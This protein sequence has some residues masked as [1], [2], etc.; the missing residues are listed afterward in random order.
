VE[1]HQAHA[2]GVLTGG[3]DAPGLNA[4]IRGVVR[5]ASQLGWSVYGFERGFEGLLPPVS[6]RRLTPD[7]TRGILHRGGTILGAV[8]RGRFVCKVGEGES[9]GIDP[10]ILE[11]S[12][13]TCR[14]LGLRGLIC[15]GGDGSLTIAQQLC[16]YGLPVV[17][18]PKT[19]DNDL[20]ATD[21]TFG[22]D[23]AVSFATD[24]LDRLHPTAAAHERVMVVEVMGRHAGWIATHAGIAGGADVILIPEFAWQLEAVVNKIRQRDAM[25]RRFSIVVAAEG[26]RWPDGSLVAKATGEGRLGEVRLGGIGQRLAEALEPL[27]GKETRCV[28][29]GHLQ[30]GGGPTTFDRL[31]ATRLGVAAVQLVA[32]GRFG[33]MVSFRGTETVDV[34][35]A[36]AIHQIRTVPRNGDLIHTARALGISFGD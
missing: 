14:S 24:A 35:I 22:F 33:R 32:Q 26:A 20:G 21:I 34:P 11:Q 7:N 15:I 6:H 18:V 30:R 25:G 3:G 36:Q 13:E 31:L 5:S 10:T 23:S 8:N 29:L 16:D 4:V 2:V 9:Q 1:T 12:A 17:G 28:V 19:I 27:T